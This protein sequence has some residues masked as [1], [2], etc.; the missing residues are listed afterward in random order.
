MTSYPN[1]NIKSTLN[2]LQLP[3]EVLLYILDYLPS[4]YLMR[5]LITCSYLYLN[6]KTNYKRKIEIGKI[7][8][9]VENL[10]NILVGWHYIK[11]DR[12][13][14]C[15]QSELDIYQCIN[16]SNGGYFDKDDYIIYHLTQL[17]DDAN[18]NQ[19]Y[20]GIEAN[21]EN[22]D[23]ICDILTKEADNLDQLI[24]KP[25]INDYLINII[26]CDT[27]SNMK[28][29]KSCTVGAKNREKLTY[30][31]IFNGTKFFHNSLDGSSPLQS[32]KYVGIDMYNI[33]TLKVKINTTDS[34]I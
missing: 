8:F 10:N 23:K 9:M 15:D 16:D 33:V 13:I 12:C 22:Y 21:A 27:L 26:R 20:R 4:R 34:E 2:L 18:E 14:G 31:D 11:Y 24:D 28:M 7:K 3:N 1:H 30:R 17:Y 32:F 25:A 29:V 5:L 6:Y 19:Q